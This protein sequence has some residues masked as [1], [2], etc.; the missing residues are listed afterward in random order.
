MNICFLKK[1]ESTFLIKYIKYAVTVF[2][3]YSLFII[4]VISGTVTLAASIPNPRSFFRLLW[5][6]SL[7][8][9]G[10]SGLNNLMDLLPAMN[11]LRPPFF[12][13]PNRVSCYA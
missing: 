7:F 3:F 12:F 11:I 1:N 8:L 6:C 2:I 5:S 9:M 13:I 4:L 10:R